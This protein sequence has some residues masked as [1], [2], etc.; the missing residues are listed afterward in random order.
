[1][2]PKVS[3]VFFCPVGSTLTMKMAEG[4]PLTAMSLQYWARST[5]W[6]RQ[7]LGG[8]LDILA[9]GHLVT[10]KTLPPLY[11]KEKLN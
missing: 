1:M 2:I 3:L 8:C 7:T 10:V 9:W 4:D 11:L 6:Y 5:S